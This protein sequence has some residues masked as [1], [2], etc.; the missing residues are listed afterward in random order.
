MDMLNDVGRKADKADTE[1]VRLV[2]NYLKK[3]GQLQYA[4]DMY[5]KVMMI[6]SEFID[7]QFISVL[8]SYKQPT[9]ALIF[10]S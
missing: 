2:A 8:N 6:S 10:F 1:A 7:H 9:G 5:K 4:R 3:L